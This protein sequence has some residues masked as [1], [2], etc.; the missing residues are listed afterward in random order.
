MKILKLSFLLILG[1]TLGFA[2]TTYYLIFIA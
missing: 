1:I 2:G